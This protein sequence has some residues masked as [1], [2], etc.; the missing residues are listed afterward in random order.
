MNSSVQHKAD[1]QSIVYFN[2]SLYNPADGQPIPAQISDI[3]SA[4]IIELPE[5]WEASI[6]RFDLSAD[7]LPPILLPMPQPPVIGAS[8]PSLLGVSLRHLGVVYPAVVNIPSFNITYYGVV[9]S[10]DALMSALNTALAAAFAAIPAPSSSAPPVFVFDPLTQLIGLYTQ[11]TYTTA[12]DPIDILMNSVA[13]SYIAS[14]PATFLG[15]NQ[16]SGLDFIL[17]PNTPSSVT[18]PGVGSRE[19]LPS[20][21]QAI[22]GEL[23]V[24]YQAGVSTSALNG[25]RS[26]FITTSMPINPEA[27]P[28]SIVSGQNSSYSSN[29]LPIL[30]DFLVGV[31]AEKANPVSDR[32]QLLYLPTSEYRMAQMRGREPLKRVDLQFFFTAFD[33][34][35][36]PVLIKPGGYVSAKIMFRRRGI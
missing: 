28:L 2:S 8:V 20:I 5:E 19:G 10:V 17:T 29:S 11:A 3:R 35:T 12:A 6:V 23:R 1:P 34:R 26:V 15:Y 30:S 22:A 18:L 16:P 27:L 32:L 7:L 24:V 25:V 33:G 31:G 21:V 36:F 4:A 14:I 9:F 13:Y